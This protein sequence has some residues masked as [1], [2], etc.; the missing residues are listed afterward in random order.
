M[1]ILVIE[2]SR[3]ILCNILEY[4]GN[5][6]YT[7][8]SAEDGLTGL[9][10]AATQDFDLIILDLMI[11]GLDGISLCQ[12]LR[13]ANIQTPVIILTARDSVQDKLNGFEVGADDYLVKPFSLMELEAR[14]KAV[15]KR[16]RNPT[17]TSI[18]QVGNLTYNTTTLEVTRAGRPIKLNPTGLKLLECLM[19]ESPNVV[20]RGR[21]EEAIWGDDPCDSDA[22][23]AHIHTLRQAI[24]KPFTKP[25]LETVHRIGYR[26]LDKI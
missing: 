14:I 24:D 21:L 20:R 16:N 3:D 18:L 1:R 6:G 17:G 12:H 7:T 4:L 15:L 26:L 13:D 5:H 11:P 22:L 9:H 25:L 2:D 23:R 19:R 8:D 10:L